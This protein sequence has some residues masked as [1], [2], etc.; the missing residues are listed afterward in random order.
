MS[1]LQ[2]EW[3]Q[4]RKV[5]DMKPKEAVEYIWE[6]FKWPIIGGIAA[7]ILLIYGIHTLLAPKK[8]MVFEALVLN[9]PMDGETEEAL[10]EGFVSYAGID[11]EQQEY[12]IDWGVPRDDTGTIA[13]QKLMV[14]LAAKDCDLVA[15]DIAIANYMAKGEAAADLSE[16]LGEDFLESYEGRIY[17]I[18]MARIRAFQEAVAAGEDD[19]KEGDAQEVWI[20]KDSQGMGDPLAVGLDVGDAV[21]GSG[22]AICCIPATVK[23]PEMARQFL[24]YLEE[25]RGKGA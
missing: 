24:R 15:G 23:R 21:S 20:S 18:D 3:E 9:I 22:E 19:T 6:Y 7:V 13:L 14:A 4:V 5:R 11:L 12:V 16:L 2:E 17:Y 10:E 8:E 1:V 25:R